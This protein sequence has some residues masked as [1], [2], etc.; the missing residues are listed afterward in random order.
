MTWDASAAVNLDHYN[1]YFSLNPG[2]AKDLLAEVPGAETSYIDHPRGLSEGINC[3]EVTAI[4]SDGNESEPS[5]E[6]CFSAS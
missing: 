4:D 1:V 2:D 6:A 5:E 3:Y